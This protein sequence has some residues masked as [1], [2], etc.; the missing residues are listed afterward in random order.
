MEN[1]LRQLQK[2]INYVLSRLAA[3]LLIAMTFLVIYQVFTRYIL[4]NP[5][6]FTEEIVRYLLIWLGFVGAAY[7]FSTREHIALFFFRD[8][9][10]AN[11]RRGLIIAMDALVLVTIFAIMVVGGVKLVYSARMEFSPIL[12]IPRSLVYAMGP[13]SGVLI[14]FLQ[15]IHLWEDVTGKDLSKEKEA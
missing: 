2:G 9:L 8:K 13:V 11:L 1:N 4:N 6:D 3:L 7:A 14:A 10:P 15:L 12:F 5:A